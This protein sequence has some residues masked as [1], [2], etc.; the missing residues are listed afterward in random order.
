MNNPIAKRF[1]ELMKLSGDFVEKQK[2]IWNV[3]TWMAFLSDISEN[4]VEI[5]KEIQSIMGSVLVSMKKFYDSVAETKGLEYRME[6]IALKIVRFVIQRKGV[7]DHSAWEAFLRD[8]QV[9]GFSLTREAMDYLASVLES[10]RELYFATS[11]YT[12][13]KPS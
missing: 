12:N 13:N 3:N 2:D 5:T 7:W 10:A 1:E 9:S 4:G 8:I 11:I 6:D